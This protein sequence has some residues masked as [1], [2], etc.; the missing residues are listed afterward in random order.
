MSSL[1]IINKTYE[2]YKYF[3]DVN[4]HMMKRWRLNLGMSIESSILTILE[5]LIIA[6][7]AP[8]TMKAAYLLRA[9]GSLEVLNFKVRLLLEL[10]V[11]NETRVF[12]MQAKVQEIGRMLGG[13]L[14]AT[15]SQ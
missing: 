11:V 7:N 8:K 4:D 5:Q 2:L 15:Q 1:P 6:K 14:K 13:W 3:T 9:S 10:G 12:Q